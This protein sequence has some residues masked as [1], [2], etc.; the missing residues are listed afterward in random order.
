[1]KI[2]EYI[3]FCPSPGSATQNPA[4]LSRLRKE[5]FAIRTPNVPQPGFIPRETHVYWVAISIVTV[6]AGIFVRVG[7]GVMT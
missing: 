5:G 6:R 7:S 3:P 4:A 1:M 2:E